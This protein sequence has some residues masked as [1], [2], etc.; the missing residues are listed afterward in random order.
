[1][2]NLS[3]YSIALFIFLVTIFLFSSHTGMGVGPDSIDFLSNGSAFAPLYNKLLV[4]ISDGIV[5]GG[6]KAKYVNLSLYLVTSLMLFLTVKSVN[7]SILTALVATSAFSLNKYI[8]DIY[9]TVHNEA[10]A[11]CIVA[12]MFYLMARYIKKESKW[13]LLAIAFA[14]GLIPP[15]RYAFSSV[16]VSGGFFFLLYPGRGFWKRIYESTAYSIVTMS[17]AL[18]VLIV[19]N[20]ISIGE[21]KVAGRA[22]AFR[23]NPDWECYQQGIFSISFMF[24]PSQFGSIATVLCAFLILSLIVAIMVTCYSSDDLFFTRCSRHYGIIVLLSAL[25]YA[26]LLLTAV[27]IEANLPLYGRYMIL[28]IYF[29]TLLAGVVTNLDGLKFRLGFKGGVVILFALL[30]LYFPANILR[31]VKYA[32]QTNKHGL[33]YNHS[34]WRYSPTLLGTN[35][36]PFEADAVIFSNGKDVLRWHSHLSVKKLPMKI[37]RRTGLDFGL[38]YDERIRISKRLLT[39][40]NGYYIHFNKIKWRFYLPT[41]EET[42]EIFKLHPVLEASDGTIYQSSLQDMSLE[43]SQSSTGWG[44]NDD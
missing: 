38:G 30:L 12:V 11:L 2:E 13:Q 37:N 1:M 10:L 5:D 39:L 25:F 6:Q 24:F 21:G 32:L 17:T 41:E 44:D 27:Q 19:N 8:L 43:S 40:N 33:A 14:A 16:I 3:K 36:F 23:G 15:S 26:I 31:V 29:F 28:F 4:S 34:D 22:L 18:L 20:R 9:L 35:T 7:G 42:I